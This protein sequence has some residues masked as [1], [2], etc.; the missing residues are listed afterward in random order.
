[1]TGVLRKI[2]KIIGACLFGIYVA[3]LIYFLFLAESYGRGAGA[4]AY[5]YNIRPFREICRY[6]R[7]RDILGHRTVLINLGG[8]IV[9]FIPL[10][11]L[12]PLFLRGIRRVWKT[13]LLGF[14]ISAAVEITQLCLHVGSFD[15]D[16]II[17]NTLGTVIGYLIFRAAYAWY[18]KWEERRRAC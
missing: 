9:G 12:L 2:I 13:G 10:G 1:M 7:Y 8:N 17:L 16:D 4:A 5:D 11:A 6:L 18:E 15:V 14:S 3:G